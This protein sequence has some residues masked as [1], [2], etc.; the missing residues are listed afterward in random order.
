MTSTNQ[1]IIERIEMEIER[2]LETCAPGEDAD[3]AVSVQMLPGN[4]PGQFMP[5]LIAVITMPGVVLGERSQGLSTILDLGVTD[6]AIS[7]MTRG[8]V[9]GIRKSRTEYLSAQTDGPATN[10]PPS[11]NGSGLILP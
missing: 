10:G 1:N 3:Y 7:D 9:E 5:A 11:S 8:M 2:T 6:E 4:Q